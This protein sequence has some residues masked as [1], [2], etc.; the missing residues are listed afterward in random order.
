[1]ALILDEIW[2]L[3][4]GQ[5][6]THT[7]YLPA[8]NLSLRGEQVDKLS[9]PICEPDFLMPCVTYDLEKTCKTLLDQLVREFIKFNI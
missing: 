4:F 2:N 1:M 3:E 6:A 8:N 7:K 5:N 9:F